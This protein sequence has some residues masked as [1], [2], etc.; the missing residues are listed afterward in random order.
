LAIASVHSLPANPLWDFT[1]YKQICSG[2]IIIMDKMVYSFECIWARCISRIK[3]FFVI[4]LREHAQSVTKIRFK[5]YLTLL[6]PKSINPTLIT[7][8]N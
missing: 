2:E 7:T 5:P 1:S 8:G 3:C 4:W 6:N